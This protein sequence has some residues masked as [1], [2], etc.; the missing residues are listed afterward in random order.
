MTAVGE[1]IAVM[2]VGCETGGLILNG[3]IR[4]S[5]GPGSVSFASGGRLGR[6]DDSMVGEA[7]ERIDQSSCVEPKI[8]SLNCQRTWCEQDK[9]QDKR[10]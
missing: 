8:V 5:G 6:V 7:V 10:S 2:T 9:K 3:G 4:G 1:N